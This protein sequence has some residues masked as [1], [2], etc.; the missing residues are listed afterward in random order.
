MILSCGAV[1]TA[2]LLLMSGGPAGIANSSGTVGRYATFHLFGLGA[3]YVMPVEFQ[4]WLHAEFGHTGTRMSY[5]PY[6]LKDKDNTKWLKGGILT[7]IG[8]K[9]PLEST[10]RG[11]D[12]A[13]T[14]EALLEEA[15][16]N[17]RRIDVRF[18]GDDLPRWDCTVDLDPN[19]VDEYGLPV[20]RITR[21]LGP[22]EVAVDSATEVWMEK[23][24]KPLVGRFGTR[25]AY[26][27]Q[28]TI[29][30]LLGDHQMGTCRMG[31]D[32]S[33]AVLDRW[34]RSHDIPNLFVVD[35]SFMPT[36]FGLNPM[37]TVVANA[38]R[39]GSWIV[40]QHRKGLPIDQ[41]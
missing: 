27:F 24:F 11:V 20:A 39:V 36:G 21:P 4:G 7:G 32:P 9:N 13:K 41:P 14:G 10:L 17:A 26:A 37:V 35:T 29:P 30:D 5:E 6:F 1:Q 8:R 28:K 12:K 2:R 34:C 22:E 40:D 16:K 31:D 19:Y 15:E 25:G 33:R 38:L 18:T 3:R 23:L